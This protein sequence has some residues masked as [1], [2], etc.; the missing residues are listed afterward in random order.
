MIYWNFY[1]DFGP[2]NLGHVY[3]FCQLLNNKLSEPK[4]KEKIIHIIVPSD[5]FTENS[6]CNEEHQFNYIQNGLSNAN[7]NAFIVNGKL[8]KLNSMQI[9]KG[10]MPKV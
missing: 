10:Y 1:L 6:W 5:E 3:R 4:F 2:L 7:K 8:Y 9:V